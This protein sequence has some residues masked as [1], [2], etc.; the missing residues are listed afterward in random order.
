VRS[1]AKAL[2]AGS[3]SG[4]GASRRPFRRSGALVA[5]LV[6]LTAAACLIPSSAFAVEVRTLTESFG[7]DGTS[8]TSFGSPSSLAFDQSNKH[9]YVVEQTGQKIHGFDASTP[10]SHAPLG[11]SFPLSRSIGSFDDFAVD[12][13]THHLYYGSFSA[14]KIFGFDESGTELAGFPVSVSDFSLNPCGLA[15][16]S[17]GNVWAANGGLETIN[18]YS[19]SGSLIQTYNVG[20]APCRLAFD[21]Q[22]NLYVGE[23]EEGASRR[24]AAASNYT[25]STEIDSRRT[26]GI[27]VDR[28]TDEVYVAHGAKISVHE[29]NGTVLYEFGEGGEYFGELGGIAI[30]EASEEVFVSDAASQKVDVFGPPAKVPKPTTEGADAIGSSTATVHGSINPQ[31]QTVE[32]CHFEVIPT[33]QF[34]ASEFNS[35][36]SEQEFPCVP[37]AGSIPADSNP[38]AVSASVT[39]LQPGT[40]YRYRLIAANAIGEGVGA[41]RSFVS[42]PGTP[43]VEEASV[44]AVDTAEAIVSAKITPRGGETTYHVD[45]G[46][47]EAYGQSTTESVPFGFPTDNGKHVVSVHIGGLSP[48]TAYHFRFVATN[49]AGSTPGTDVSFATFPSA[50]PA[51]APCSNDQLRTGAGARLPDCRAYE[52]AS[53]IDKHGANT[54]AEIGVSS[55]VSSSGDRFTFLARGGLPTSGGIPRLEPFLAA[56]GPGGWSFDGFLPLTEPGDDASILGVSENLNYAVVKQ[57]KANRGGV[58]LFF[59]DAGTGTFEPV[60]PSVPLFEGRV[61]GFA[62]NGPHAILVSEVQLA[63]SA[64]AIFQY[65]LYDLDHGNITVADRIPAGS[66]TTCDDEAGPPCIVAPE[67]STRTADFNYISRDGTRIVFLADPTRRTEFDGRVYLREDGTRTTWISASQRTTPDPNG[68]KPAEIKYVAPD[69]SKVFF[70]S[71]EK[72]TDDSTAV[73]TNANSCKETSSSPQKPIQGQDLYSYDVETEKLTDLTVDSNSGDPLGAGVRSFGGASEDGSYLYFFADGVLAPGASPGGCVDFFVFRNECNLYVYHDGVTKFIA[74]MGAGRL[75]VSDDGRSVAFASAKSLTGYNNSTSN[76]SEGPCGEYF[77]Y[78]APAETLLCMT[79]LPTGLPPTE[80]ANLGKTDGAGGLQGARLRPLSA[81]GNRFF[82]Q[83]SDALVPGDT[84]HVEDVYEWEAKGTG[85]CESESQDGGCI[86]L[87]SSGTDPEESVFLGA[88]KNGDHAFFYSLQQ[89]VPTDQDELIDVYDASVGGGLASQHTL[90]PPS[91]D[92]TACQ[93]NPPPPPDQTPASASF[94]GPGNAHQRPSARKCPKGKRKVRRAG[95]VS[96]KK[97]H[98]QHKR[99]TNRGGAK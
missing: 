6:A 49:Q 55:S 4:R 23:F 30:D 90:A 31:E 3:N 19:S 43:L 18:E 67:G 91:C 20:G 65:N 22:D 53:P 54:Q 64:P 56:R 58:Q 50:S 73:S 74:R 15:V 78:S 62:A 72:L 11:G 96:C 32:D 16:D 95:K 52:Q 48:G 61:A 75:F 70:T 33:S 80:S 77:R 60:G 41:G 37:A 81:D 79:C 5:L 25:A 21:S 39:G 69:G 63:P 59:R 76:C 57:E 86:Y 89:L 26:F 68:E 13:S 82:F 1:H 17:S 14:G 34:Q 92:S 38:H 45:Y 28:S 36:T 44:E 47:T 29:P 87:I 9:L 88:S 27:A 12:S 40:Q 66:A 46:T 85:S 94:H 10:G 97:A 93:A 24:F 98:K 83:T 42:G 2:S 51:F 8:G 7:T 71:C 84:N 35:V 99:H